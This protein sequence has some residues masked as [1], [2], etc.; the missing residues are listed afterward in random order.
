MVGTGQAA[1]L[2]VM[3]TDT[4]GLA[5]YERVAAAIRTGI[6]EGRL[7]P[8]ERLPG[9]RA[10]AEQYKVSLP[11]L[12]KAVGVLHDEGWLVVRAAVGVFVS[13][14]PPAGHGGDPASPRDLRRTVVELQA[15]VRHL[16]ERVDRLEQD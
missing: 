1:K 4:A 11:T 3:A 16:R 15:E 13:D 9:N 6:A 14:S 5:A 8:G 12:Q 10:L 2:G 7:T